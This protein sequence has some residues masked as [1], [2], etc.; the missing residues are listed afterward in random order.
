MR[1]RWSA[2]RKD[3][4]PHLTVEP[5][6]VSAIAREL[7]LSRG[8]V[9]GRNAECYQEP[10]GRLPRHADHT[11]EGLSGPLMLVCRRGKDRERARMLAIVTRNA[12]IIRLLI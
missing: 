1:I 9:D 5:R 4:L 3:L 6:S 2:F 8:D 7:G 11:I 12:A 10:G